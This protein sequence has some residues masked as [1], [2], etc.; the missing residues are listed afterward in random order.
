MATTADLLTTGWR[1]HQAGEVSRAE[2]V[3]RQVVQHEPANAQGWYLLG[4][5]CQAQQKLSEAIDHYLRAVQ[6]KPDYAQAQYD[7]AIAFMLREQPTEAEGHFR[8]AVELQP[9]FAIAHHNLG[10]ALMQQGK[11]DDALIHFQESARL[12]PDSADFHRSVGSVL[13]NLGRLDEASASYRRALQLRSDYPEAHHGLGCV[14]RDQQRFPEAAAS[15]RQALRLRPDFADAHNTLGMALAKEGKTEEAL[16]SY[17]QAVR[18]RPDFAEAHNNLGLA[19]LGQDRSLEAA[20]S[21]REAVRLRPDMADAQNNFGLALHK[22]DQLAEALVCFQRTAQLRPG[23]AQVHHNLGTVL[24]HLGRFGDAVAAYRTALEL[25][26]DY[27]Q[28]YLGL[29]NVLMDQGELDDAIAA[30]RSALAL[31]PDAAH[32][33]SNLIFAL[34]YHPGYDAAA[35]LEEG[36]RWNRQHA[37]PLQERIQPHRNDPDPARRLR[38]GYVSPDFREHATAFFTISLLSNHDHGAFEIYGYAD[39]QRPDRLTERLRGHVDVWRDTLGLSDERVAELVRRDQIDILV[40]L[41]MHMA[42]NRLLVFARK[43]APVQVTWVAYPGTTGLSSMDYRLTDPYLDPPGRFDAYYAEQSIRLADTFWCYDPLIDPVPVNALP[44]VHNGYLTFGCLNN[45]WKV[46]DGVLALWA[47]VL[48]AVPQSR[49]LLLA[50]MDHARDRVLARLDEAGIVAGRVEF[51]RKQPRPEYLT[52][53]HRIDLGLDPLPYNGH[54]TSLDAFWMGVP[55]LTLIGK[56]VV[57][58][59]GWSQLCNLGL[60]EL[61][62]ATPQEFVTLAARLAGDLPRLQGLRGTLRRQMQGTP[63][64]DS[65]RFA[66]QVEQAYRQMWHRWCQSQQPHG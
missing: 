4:M 49:L 24:W 25:R 8:R 15:C 35:I 65:Q 39:V 44:A 64:M 40:D 18:L 19:L 2:Q 38:V 62:A 1:L 14:L 45:F 30:Y 51:V 12:Q 61:A 42:G 54:T 16:A 32:I 55:T 29:A 31:K 50:P 66:R 23:D 21:F 34:Q 26:P 27:A 43:P 10:L 56:T 48:Q 36:R 46:N 41:T 52:L 33:H 3:Y 47:K 58:R 5:A 9:T 63:L 22:Q 7:L 20:A 28:A 57:G 11:L 37:A 53:Y 13:R 60:Q 59:A 17:Q 6:F